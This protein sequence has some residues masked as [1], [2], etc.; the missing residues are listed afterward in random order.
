M[1][2]LSFE[3]FTGQS[4]GSAP[5][6]A[7]ASSG[8]SFE[9]FTNGS[10]A[11]GS[12]ARSPLRSEQ[13]QQQTGFLANI[14][15]GTSEA[16]AGMLGAP[17][18][19]A[20]GALNLIP[21]GVNAVDGTHIPT[22]QNPVGGSEWWKSAQ[23]MI[24]ADPRNMAPADE[25]EQ[26]GRAAGSGAASAL[27][28]FGVARG[29]PAM[30]GLAG[31]A[32]EAFGAGSAGGQAAIGAGAGAAGQYAE[33]RVPE[34]L[35]PLANVAGQLA[36]GIGVAAAGAGARALVRGAG[37]IGSN[38]VAPLTTAGRKRLAGERIAG[39][40]SDPA[41][42][43]QALAD[44]QPAL[45]PGSQ[46]TTY[47]LTGDPGLGQLERV[48][49]KNNPELFMQRA[50]D[51]NA[52]RVQA[53]EQLAPENASPD[54]VGA[55]FRQQ[56][57][58]LDAY[59][60][61]AVQQAQDAA[62]QAIDDIG[63]AVPPGSDQQ[64]TTLQ[65]YGERLRAGL[66]AANADAKSAESKL[67]QAI[68][69]DGTLT[70]NMSPVRQEA[71]SILRDIP[72]N[73]GPLTGDERNIFS[74]AINLP[75]VQP[76]AELGALRSRITDAIRSERMAAGGDTQTTRRLSQLL[77]GVHDALQSAVSRESA[78]ETAAVRAG[79]LDPQQTMLGRFQQSLENDRQQLP[80][81][82]ANQNELAPGL[83]AGV[84]ESPAL[85]SQPG[86]ASAQRGLL[87]DGGAQAATG[88]GAIG[89]NP[90]MAAQP[91]NVANFDADAAA[92]YAA[93]RQATAER[94]ATFTNAPGVGQ[95]LKPG[96]T[97]GTYR[98]PDSQVAS[99]IFN[100]A[101]GAAEKVQAFLKAGGSRDDLLN[102]M[103]DYAAFDLRRAAEN[104]DTGML[105]QAKYQRW[106]QGHSEAMAAFPELQQRFQT[107]ADASQAVDQAIAN[108]A[109]ATT[110]FQKSAAA[111]FLGDADPVAKVGRILKSDKSAAT[112]QDLARMTAG[113]RDARAGLQR[114]VAEYMLREMRGNAD[115]GGTGNIKSD[116][117]QTFVR[118]STPA[119]GKIFSPKQIKAMQDIA[120]DLQMANR[121]ISGT[122]LPGGSNTAQ[123]LAAQGKHGHNPSLLRH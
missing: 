117:F 36:G 115:M 83:G 109:A 104:P 17:V 21:R 20:T 73:S 98:L 101:P 118:K 92:R 84:T 67:W 4:G 121:S 31:A 11:N 49:A 41:A 66:A 35:K 5:D 7:L 3:E 9:D 116:A 107:A 72:V 34:P 37:E 53:I 112:M 33:N 114:S 14:G 68:D 74:T 95:V 90:A 25:T 100:G 88:Q 89:S 60:G 75:N 87:G 78:D 39:A 65:Q 85:A 55:A 76:F 54:A 38:F 46:L 63:G 123:D 2:G 24:G 64:T 32:Q 15:A 42:V 81:P 62:R 30:R 51:N 6:S 71:R 113:N 110:A 50:A 97:A 80:G 103:H 82:A 94:K 8:I 48:A 105:N 40:A 106:M 58:A 52:A 23:G 99:T 86:A 29:L 61:T 28:P 70:V 91:P 108:R 119:L 1:S 19:I 16:V 57:D 44:Q 93:A 26:L 45:V 18:D 102:A 111:N 12:S 13:S 122:K 59:H 27:L 120:T 47:Q 22:I 79:V 43:R 10:N 69:P 96:Q 56:L 77:G